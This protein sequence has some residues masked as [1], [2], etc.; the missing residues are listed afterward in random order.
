MCKNQH[1]KGEMLPLPYQWIGQSFREKMSPQNYVS[2]SQN[3][4]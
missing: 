3:K 4:G 2:S 1:D